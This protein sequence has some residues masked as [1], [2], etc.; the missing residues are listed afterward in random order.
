[1]DRYVTLNLMLVILQWTCSSIRIKR[2][3]SFPRN[4]YKLNTPLNSMALSTWAIVH[5]NKKEL[6]IE[7]VKLK[8]KSYEEQ[9]TINKWQNKFHKSLV[10]LKVTTAETKKY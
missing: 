10:A 3:V 5:E 4:D 8:S 2:L 1:M 7:L 6:T 9:Q